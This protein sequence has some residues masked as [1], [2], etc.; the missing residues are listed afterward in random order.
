MIERAACQGIHQRNQLGRCADG[1]LPV[2]WLCWLV[3][4]YDRK[5]RTGQ[6]NKLSLF[7]YSTGNLIEEIPVPQVGIIE[8]FYQRDGKDYLYG[9]SGRFIIF[10]A[11]AKKVVTSTDPNFEEHIFLIDNNVSYSHKGNSLI[12][13]N[14]GTNTIAWQVEIDEPFANPL[15]GEGMIF[16]RT[17]NPI[18][19]GN[20]YAINEST[21]AVVWKKEVGI[22][23]NIE[24]QNSKLY[25][26]T[27]DGFL[28][29]LDQQSGQVIARIQFTAAPFLIS[30][31]QSAIGGYYVSVDADNKIIIVAVGDSCQLM[32]LKLESP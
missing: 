20:I 12:A 7:A 9:S 26:L 31:S 19:S 32:A 5:E 6:N 11:S 29:I 3:Y 24:A 13:F 21:G 16:I 14:L 2:F 4:R 1:H 10:D 30:S 18:Y 28:N 27:V 23:S 25:F 17:G 8:S 15:F 22:I